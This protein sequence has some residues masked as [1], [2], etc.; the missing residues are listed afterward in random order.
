MQTNLM[1]KSV[2]VIKNKKVLNKIVVEL[3]T[4]EPRDQET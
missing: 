3:V 1:D 2:F 4:K